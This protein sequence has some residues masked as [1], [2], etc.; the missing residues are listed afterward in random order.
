MN[1]KDNNVYSR[2]QFF[3]KAAQTALPIL[4]SVAVAPLLNGCYDPD[5]EE[6][7]IDRSLIINILNHFIYNLNKVDR[8]IFL[9][10]YY[11]FET[12]NS[13]A[14]NTGLSVNSVITPPKVI[15][16]PVESPK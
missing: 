8:N 11:G 14:N 16:S 4:A 12:I 10:R 1:M 9:S 2:R 3:K 5:F 7:L 6:T 13:I 15:F